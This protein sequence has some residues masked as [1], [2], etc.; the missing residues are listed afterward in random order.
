MSKYFSFN[1]I[2]AGFTFMAF[3]RI[4]IFFSR[5]TCFGNLLKLLV[6]LDDLSESSSIENLSWKSTNSSHIRMSFGQLRTCLLYFSVFSHNS[7][8]PSILMSEVLSI[9]I[10]SF[11]IPLP[12]T[13]AFVPTSIILSLALSPRRESF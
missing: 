9:S 12:S 11:W 5:T 8:F 1:L 7:D 13:Y 6:M 2:H 3:S 10:S 4:N